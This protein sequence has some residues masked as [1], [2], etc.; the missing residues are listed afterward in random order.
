M[1]KFY[2]YARLNDNDVCIEIVSRVNKLQDVQGY[3]ELPEYNET[4]RY[5]KWLGDQW[6]QETYEPSLDT[7]L[8]DKIKE[9]EGTN[10][11][12]EQKNLDLKLALAELAE[13][14]EAK[15]TELQ[16]ALAE[17]AERGEING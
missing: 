7:V 9:L 12:L 11:R 8:Q 1:K 17:L 3:V 2:Y 15:I 4:V 13:I 5:R 16:I 6:S 10:L 14:Q